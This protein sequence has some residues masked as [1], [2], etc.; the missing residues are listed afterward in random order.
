MEV[1][2]FIQVFKQYYLY[3]IKYYII[4]FIQWKT[5]LTPWIIILPNLQGI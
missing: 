3:I 4:I 5:Q 1:K 2:I